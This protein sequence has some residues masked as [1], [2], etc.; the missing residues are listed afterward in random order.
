MTLPPEWAH[1][2]LASL[3][4]RINA[5]TERQLSRL[6]ASLAPAAS[7][8]EFVDA[9][10]CAVSGGKR[11]RGFLALVGADLAGDDRSE[12]FGGG[13]THRPSQEALDT[14]AA[15][16]E[17]FQA[18]ALVHD[19]LIDHAESRRGQPTSHVRFADVHRVHEWTGSPD[20]FGSAGALLVGD[21]LLSAADHALAQACDDIDPLTV[22]S[23]LDRFT[24]MHA[25]VAL[26]Q[27]LDVRAEHL[28]LDPDD[29]AS[30][31]VDDSLEVVRR[32]SARYSVVHPLVLGMLAAGASADRV[33]LVGRITEPWGIAFQ[34]RDD[35]LGVFG[36][37]VTTGKPAGDDLREGKRTVLLALTWTASTNN[38]RA[39]LAAGLGRTDLDED[40]IAH[41]AGIVKRRGR[42][43][44]EQLIDTFVA[45]GTAELE[46]SNLDEESRTR[47]IGLAELLTRR[48]S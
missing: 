39:D 8:C 20:E 36:D 42:A 45:R 11:L 15:A 22:A 38:E 46:V 31:S 40:A 7:G 9:A 26:G 1:T 13:T 19:D 27:Y 35:D 34:L 23:V 3:V 30:M 24:L 2:D 17:L 25:E 33:D 47:L 43:A 10:S 32:K 29:A 5:A 4:P 16:L 18:S 14:L 41:L 12:R 37:P 44:H 6:I 48:R 21:L 28:Q